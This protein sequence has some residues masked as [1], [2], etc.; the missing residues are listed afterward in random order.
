[1]AI[2]TNSGI[3]AW[4]PERTTLPASDV[5]P[6]ALVLNPLVATIAATPQGDA[7]YVRIPFIAADPDAEIVAEGE[8]LPEGDATRAEIHVYARKIGILQKISREAYGQQLAGDNASAGASD[9]FTESLKRAVTAKLDGMF[10]NAPE[11]R[12]DVYAPG[13]ATDTTDAVIDAGI[14]AG[15]LDPIV[16]ALALVSD[17]GA[18]PTC[19]LT[20]NS[21][22]AALQKL[23][24]A[25]GRPVV[26][27][28]AQEA[29]LPQIA[30]L[31]VVRSAAVP[32]DKLL[33]IDAANIIV[34]LTDV[35]VDV[36]ASTYF[37]SDSIAVRATARLGWGIVQRGRIARL[38]IGQTDAGNG[39]QTP[40]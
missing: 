1:M 37:R 23:K 2:N 38:T 3:M 5:T 17:N 15:N 18:S 19:I 22:W 25:D 36:D 32:K 6:E 10:V 13:L 8:D 26:N 30:G 20:S 14:I 35:T 21:G 9:L 34:A 11:R 12:D 40:R 29:A 28:A 33:I 27:P 39:T 4:N 16:D 7:S 31:P 24:Y